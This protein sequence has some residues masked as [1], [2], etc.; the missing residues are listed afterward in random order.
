MRRRSALLFFPVISMSLILGCGAF[1]WAHDDIMKAATTY[2][3][4]AAPAPPSGRRESLPLF[5]PPNLPRF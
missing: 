5:E 2:P 4:Q 1:I 3:V